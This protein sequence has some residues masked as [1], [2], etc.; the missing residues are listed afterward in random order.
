MSVLLYAGLCA[1]LF[2][3]W[4]GLVIIAGSQA[5]RRDSRKS[6]LPAEK[7]SSTLH[8]I[9]QQLEVILQIETRYNMLISE[10]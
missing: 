10:L 4:V 2:L 8:S 7:Q 5:T 9:K 1:W 3:N 6:L